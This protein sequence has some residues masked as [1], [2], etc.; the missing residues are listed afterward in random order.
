MSSEQPP[1]PIDTN[2]LSEDSKRVLANLALEGIIPSTELLADLRLLDSEQ[3]S[4]DDFKKRAI[5][6]AIA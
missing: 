6:R 4:L 5:A 3:L 2:T 1:K